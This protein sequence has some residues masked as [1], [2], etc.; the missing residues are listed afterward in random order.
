MKATTRIIALVSGLA[1]FQCALASDW[2]VDSGSRIGFVATYDSIPFQAWFKSFDARIR[3]SPN[4]LDDSSFDVRIATSSLDSDSPDRD[5]GMKQAEWFAVDK[6]P[7]ARFQATHF[8]WVAENRYRAIGTLTVK[9]VSKDVDV[10]FAWEPQPGG[11]VWLNAQA[12]L[13]RGDFDIGTGEWAQDDTIGYDVG[14]NASL[15]LAP[16]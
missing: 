5:E 11:N 7:Q 10:L 14:V 9:G 15:K 4:Q 13:K 3:F 8:E 16:R 2:K 12:R 1:L 6:Y